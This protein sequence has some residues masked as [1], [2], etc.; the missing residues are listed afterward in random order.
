VARQVRIPD[1]VLRAGEFRLFLQ[2]GSGN[3]SLVY[4]V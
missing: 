2:G 4:E 1:H 3:S